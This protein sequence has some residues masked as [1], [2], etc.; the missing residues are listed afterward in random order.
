LNK[1]FIM[2]KSYMKSLKRKL[3]LKNNQ[4]NYQKLRENPAPFTVTNTKDEHDEDSAS[5]T[6]KL[7]VN[8]LRTLVREYRRGTPAPIP[9]PSS[10]TPR[11]PKRSQIMEALTERV[12]SLETNEPGMRPTKWL[13]K[14]PATEPVERQSA[15]EKLIWELQ[16]KSIPVF[17][18]ERQTEMIRTFL[19]TFQQATDVMNMGEK[20][21]TDECDLY[22][23]AGT[24]SKI[25][26]TE[27]GTRTPK[28]GTGNDKTMA[29]KTEKR[30]LPRR[31]V[32]R[33]MGRTD[34]SPTGSPF[35]TMVGRNIYRIKK[36][37]RAQDRTRS[38]T[39]VRNS[40]KWVQQF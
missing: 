7:S 16:V 20:R 11:S 19:S 40:R 31:N 3:Q 38:G 21:N 22:I 37:S 28:R 12:E 6:E 25:V 15:E 33:K 30:L 2:L 34:R 17:N 14:K 27:R 9:S 39:A 13:T 5:E 10:E 4:R 24:I 23:Q 32:E 29:K 26:E 1:D 36:P 18:G 8:A 35:T